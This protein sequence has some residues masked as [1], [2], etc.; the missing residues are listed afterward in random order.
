[1]ILKAPKLTSFVG[2]YNCFQGVI[3]DEICNI[4][5][6]KTFNAPGLTSGES[7]RIHIWKGSASLQKTFPTFMV[8]YMDGS[9]P[10]CLFGMDNMKEL[11]V[12]GNGLIGRIPEIDK[13]TPL[14]T[15]LVLSNNRLK[16]VIPKDLLEKARNLTTVDVSVNFIAG[17]MDAFASVNDGERD[18]SKMVVKTYLNRLSGELP[19]GLLRL[20][21]GNID[22]LKGNVFTCGAD[23]PHND[24]YE[25]QYTCG[26]LK[27]NN[28]IYLFCTI[29]GLCIVMVM[30]LKQYDPLF[31]ETCQRKLRLWYEWSGN[32]RAIPKLNRWIQRI[33]DLLARTKLRNSKSIYFS[34]GLRAFQEKVR[35]SMDMNIVIENVRQYMYGLRILQIVSIAVGLLIFLS[36]IITYPILWNTNAYD[37]G[38]DTPYAWVTTAVYLS[39][40]SVVAVLCVVL[41]LFM[42]MVY[43]LALASHYCP[44][45]LT[46]ESNNPMVT[47]SN[48]DTK[49]NEDKEVDLIVS[50]KSVL[51]VFVILTLDISI[52]GAINFRYTEIIDR[53]DVALQQLASFGVAAFKL[54][55]SIYG[56][57]YLLIKNKWLYFSLNEDEA[58]TAVMRISGSVPSFLTFLN[59]LNNLLIPI[60]TFSLFGEK[61]FRYAFETQ[62]PGS[63]DYK[64]SLCEAQFNDDAHDCF[65]RSS[66]DVTES[67]VKPFVYQ[68]QCS[69]SIIQAYSNVY[70]FKYCGES[71]LCGALLAYMV[72]VAWNEEHEEVVNR[73]VDESH[74]D[75]NMDADGNS[76]TTNKADASKAT[77]KKFVLWLKRKNMFLSYRDDMNLDEIKNASLVGSGD[78]SIPKLLYP[79]FFS[80]R[81]VS[82]LAILITFSPFVPILGLIGLTAI[83]AKISVTKVMMGRLLDEL[84]LSNKSTANRASIQSGQRNSFRASQEQSITPRGKTLSYDERKLQLQ[85]E[86]LQVLKFTIEKFPVSLLWEN[87]RFIIYLSAFWYACVITDMNSIDV[88]FGRGYVPGLVLLCFP[89]V[90][91]CVGFILIKWYLPPSPAE[92][93][94]SMDEVRQRSTVNIQN[95]MHTD[96]IP[97]SSDHAVDDTIHQL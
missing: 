46:K 47:K 22:I 94:K 12:S 67:Y 55:W 32:P 26:S 65:I 70:I 30:L 31:F 83:V 11:I 9:L 27:Y 72:Y 51:R 77:M 7:C 37:S 15:S 36:M 49:E 62:D 23:I 17:S 53:D 58:D 84:S 1:M 97:A 41:I 61:C 13:I 16:G 6:I 69:S 34:G 5:S 18:L 8:Q 74:V 43:L 14:L 66:E 73:P 54:F 33:N 44:Q 85:G 71:A 64:F 29:V 52:V 76:G 79:E 10:E 86:L 80:S 19:S 92:S 68:S 95:P 96:P 3:S 42:T 56:M 39:G 25:Y 21:R 20:K 45:Y 35:Q 38:L 60:I 91:E 82:F 78:N 24:P 4:T 87:H 88:G 2:G 89:L 48:D 28:S 93:E 75:V 90:L 57:K 63:Y 59:L 81:I 50:M 40:Q